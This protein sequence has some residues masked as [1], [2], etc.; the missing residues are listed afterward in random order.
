[1]TKIHPLSINEICMYLNITRKTFFNW[2]EMK[3]STA[4]HLDDFWRFNMKGKLKS[5]GERRN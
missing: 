5:V 4:C 3:E 1:M 2:I